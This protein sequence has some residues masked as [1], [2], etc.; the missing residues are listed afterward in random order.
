MGIQTMSPSIFNRG[1]YSTVVGP[2]NRYVTF[3]SDPEEKT[4]EGYSL[5]NIGEHLFRMTAKKPVSVIGGQIPLEPIIDALN[6]EGPGR[7]IIGVQKGGEKT[8][9]FTIYKHAMAS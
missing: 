1:K 7:I 5:E 9:T 2:Q 3:L 8:Y 4:D 6:G